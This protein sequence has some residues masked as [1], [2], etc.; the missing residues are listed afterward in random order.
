MRRHGT[1]S[2]HTCGNDAEATA[3][4]SKNKPFES[5][6]QY[7]LGTDCAV[8]EKD[9]KVAGTELVTEWKNQRFT[10]GK[11]SEIVRAT[12]WHRMPH[13]GARRQDQWNAVE[14]HHL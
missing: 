13:R 3:K 7:P 14:T 12:C 4:V 9:A 1:T 8:V 11:K 2:N 5:S 6:K 10:I